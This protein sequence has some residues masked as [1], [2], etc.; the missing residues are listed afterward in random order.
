[1]GRVPRA[2]LCVQH[3]DDCPPGYVG[4]RLVDL[5][6][7]ID[8]VD[9]RHGRLPDPRAY[10]LVVSLGSDDSAHDDAVPYLSPER[11]VLETAIRAEIPVFGICFGAQLLSRV[12]GGSVTAMH[13]G[14]EIG[15]LAVQ[16]EDPAL[17]DEGPWLIWHLDAMTAPPGALALA[18]TGRATQAFAAGRT[19]GVQFHPEVTI[20][21]AQV[22]A[23]HYGSHLAA[24]GI[25]PDAL[26]DEI[27]VRDTESRRRA[28][29]LTDRV[30]QRLGFS[31]LEAAERG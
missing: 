28:H 22:W 30:L 24:L 18:W 5:G 26:L 1:M 20:A 23:A 29:E 12:L 21:S 7:E 10:D 11:G 9:A 14:P 31:V 3:Q 6:A 2:V 13:D 4:Q 27:R 25:D 19:V 15:W 17:V 16:T 8:V